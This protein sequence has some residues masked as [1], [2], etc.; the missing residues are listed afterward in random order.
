[1]SAIC[2]AGLLPAQCPPA[3]TTDT[4]EGG[5]NQGGW[6]FILG[7]DRIEPSGGNPGAWLHNDNYDTFAPILYTTREGGSAFVGDLRAKGVISIGLDARTDATSFGP[8]TGFQMSLLL[9]DTKGTGDPTD[10]DYA[11]SVGPQV[12]LPGQ[13]WIRYQFAVPSSSTAAVPAGWSGGWAGDPAQFRPGVTW[14]DV[15]TNVDRVEFWWIDP[16]LF[17]I[18]RTWDIG[19]DN[20]TI[21]RARLARA[22]VA[23]GTGINPVTLSA[24]TLPVL[25]TTWS[26]VLDCSAHTG[27]EAMLLGALGAPRSGPI[28]PFGEVLLD[29][30]TLFVFGTQPNAGASNTFDFFVPNNPEFCGAELSQQGFCTGSPRP[31]LGNAIGFV[32]GGAATAED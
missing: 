8:P 31:Q 23:N 2:A 28:I 24:A 21:T 29:V 20:V 10:D 3:V 14:S 15:I 17:A 12:P 5:V 7:A 18:F 11:Y 32:L 16:Q 25:G 30:P 13:G 19:A 6:A 27:G 9:R 22:T 4:F 1:M 26:S